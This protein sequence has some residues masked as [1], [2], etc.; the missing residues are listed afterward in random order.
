MRFKLIFILFNFVILVSFL[1]IYFMPL[2]MLGFDY[3]K[4]FWGR[5]WGLPL[6]F[7]AIIGLLNTYF[8]FN[9]RLFTLLEREDWPQLITYLERRIY[10][11][12]LFVSQHVK[13]LANAYLVRSDLDA[14]GKLEDFIAEH[15]PNL[16]PR[17][18]LVF[19]VPY[20]LRNDPDEMERYFSRFVDYNGRD[21]SWLRWSYAFALILGG[22]KEEAEATLADIC[23]EKTE[24]VLMLLSAYLL[25]S[26]RPAADHVPLME[27]NRA[28]LEK[29]YT[30]D[31][32][33]RE[34][35]RSKTSVH[36]VILQ[37]LI[38]EATEW[39]FAANRADEENTE[40]RMH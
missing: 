17:F 13:I 16:Q 6:L 28:R 12:R 21:G 39:L 19:G 27:E 32:W 30:R 33:T 2:I 40:R 37:K 36:V 18:A 23:K 10:E 20:L 25:H 8:I 35:E 5:N 14:I 26:I 34:V 29:R 24:P 4:V 31:Q 1:A 15:K 9:W 11:K 3:A 38:E 22:K 7:L